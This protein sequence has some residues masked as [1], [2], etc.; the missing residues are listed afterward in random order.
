MAKEFFKLKFSFSK[1]GGV[2]DTTSIA[3][4]M[5]YALPVNEADGNNFVSEFAD[6]CYDLY[7]KFETEGVYGIEKVVTNFGIHYIMFT[8]VINQGILSLEDEFTLVSD[9]KV[10]DYFYESILKKKES[11]IS[12]DIGSVLYNQYSNAG[13]IEIKYDNYEDCL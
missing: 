9:Q 3:N 2:T 11:T 6:T 4:L 7:D 10:G 12:S 5:G 13:L 8:G 1:D